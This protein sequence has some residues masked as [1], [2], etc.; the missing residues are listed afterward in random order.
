MV[1]KE[2]LK[3]LIKRYIKVTL[4][5]GSIHSGFIGNPEDFQDEM[6]VNMILVNG[7]MRDSVEI[8]R[9]VDVEFPDREDNLK[10][11]ITSDK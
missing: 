2:L 4:D 1:D 7:L 5:D 6:P 11:N 3:E 10:L 9:V 8:N